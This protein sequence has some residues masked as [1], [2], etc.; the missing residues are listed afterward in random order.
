MVLCW[1]LRSVVGGPPVEDDFLTWWL[2]RVADDDIPPPVAFTVSCSTN[3]EI[4]IPDENQLEEVLQCI[5][6]LGLGATFDQLLEQNGMVY[7]HH[8]ET[9]TVWLATLAAVRGEEDERA[10]ELERQA[11]EFARAED[12]KRERDERRRS[13]AA[14]E[15]R[16]QLEAEAVRRAKRAEARAMEA[17]RREAAAR[18]E[19]ERQAAMERE[20][21]RRVE[22]CV[23][24]R[25]QE[26]EQE[27]LQ[28]PNVFVLLGR[29]EQALQRTQEQEQKRLELL[30]TMTMLLQN[31]QEEQ[32]EL[33]K[34]HASRLV[35]WVQ[36]QA[37]GRIAERDPPITVSCDRLGD[38]VNALIVGEGGNEMKWA[39]V[40]NTLH[41][42]NIK[43]G[44]A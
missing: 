34:V 32:Q 2:G 14:L 10:A 8:A 27:V 40:T 6:G 33:R 13:D 41:I 23:T 26:A 9:A 24:Q 17:A 3:D 21:Q 11:E 1:L 12:D 36:Q 30:A 39:G 25:V 16:R 15:E 31:L 43:G 28:V 44:A 37:T 20:I 35:R 4:L 38:M 18:D 22:E 29:L 7:V 5:D 19:A 42:R